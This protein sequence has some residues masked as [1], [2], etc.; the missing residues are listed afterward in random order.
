M[1]KGVKTATERKARERD[2]KRSEGLRPHEVWAHASDWPLI[3]RLVERLAKRRSKS[4]CP[5]I[6]L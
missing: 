6:R 1:G 3:R 4:K 2:R 5:Q